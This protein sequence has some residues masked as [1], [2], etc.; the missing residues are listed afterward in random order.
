MNRE[1]IIEAL[2]CCMSNKV[3]CNVC[4][5]QKECEGDPFDAPAVRHSLTLIYDLIAE[6]EQLK[7]E[8]KK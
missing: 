4:P 1:E 6:I 3:M 2:E 8:R 7:T 5:L